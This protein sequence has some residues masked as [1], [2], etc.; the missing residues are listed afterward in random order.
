MVGAGHVYGVVQC[1][2]GIISYPLVGSFYESSVPFALPSWKQKEDSLEFSY[3]P[4]YLTCLLWNVR[5]GFHE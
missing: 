2:K 1:G 5:L 3:S 4:A